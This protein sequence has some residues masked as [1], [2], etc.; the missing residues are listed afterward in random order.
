MILQAFSVFDSKAKTFAAPW[1]A[2][3]EQTA[4]RNFS[5]AVNDPQTQLNKFPEDF[6]LYHIGSFNDENG[7]LSRLD[8]AVNLGLA[9]Q[10]RKE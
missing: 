8:Q 7:E 4:K 5:G 3:N 6:T 10:Y 2:V 9:A 1:W